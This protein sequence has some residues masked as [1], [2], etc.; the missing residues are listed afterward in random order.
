MAAFGTYSP[1]AHVTATLHG[2]IVNLF[3]YVTPLLPEHSFLSRVCISLSQDEA[4]SCCPIDACYKHQDHTTSTP[5]C[6]AEMVTCFFQGLQQCADASISNELTGKKG[7]SGAQKGRM[8][9]GL[10]LVSKP[11]YI[12][13]GEP[14]SGLDTEI[15][16]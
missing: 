16:E 15:A 7:I 9:V 5:A 6:F 8:S 11:W 10:E 3:Y 12:F 4:T 1:H 2:V 13:L 14:T